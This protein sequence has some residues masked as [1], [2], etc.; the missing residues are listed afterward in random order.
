MTHGGRAFLFQTD[1]NESADDYAISA[2]NADLQPDLLSST[3]FN[4]S[5]SLDEFMK[6]KLDRS[7]ISR[8]QYRR[9]AFEKRNRNRQVSSL[10]AHARN[11]TRFHI[12]AFAQFLLKVIRIIRIG[13]KRKFN[14]V[15]SNFMSSGTFGFLRQQQLYVA[16]ITRFQ[17]YFDFCEFKPRFSTS[18]K[19]IS[20]RNGVK[21]GKEPNRS[22]SRQES[23]SYKRKFLRIVFRSFP[24]RVIS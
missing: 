5:T 24:L 8:K 13:H 2:P 22:R 17:E 16:R 7:R 23:S 15:G 6:F 12:A 19:N 3:S 11:G 21:F 18:I 4:V 20:L 1:S 14:S 9:C 10:H